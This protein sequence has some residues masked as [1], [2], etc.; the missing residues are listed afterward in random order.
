MKDRLVI[1]LDKW[2]EGGRYC[3]GELDGSIFGV[4]NEDVKECGSLRYALNA[5]MHGEELLLSGALSA[6]FRLQ[7]ARCLREFEYELRLD[8]VHISLEV[9]G[10]RQVDVTEALREEL[11]IVLPAYP[12]CEISGLECDIKDGNMHFGLDKEGMPEV[13]SPAAGDGKVWDV[14][15]HL[16]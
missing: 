8:D 1:S 16:K 15:D 6:R 14:L 4:E 7:C 12:K 13:E 10:E 11:V 2:P 9:G 5:Q 3:E